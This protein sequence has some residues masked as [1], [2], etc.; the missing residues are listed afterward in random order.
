[1]VIEEQFTS[2]E[3]LLSDSDLPLL[4]MFY[5]PWCGPSH[6]M[7]TVLEQVESR[8]SQ[9][10]RIAKINSEAHPDL[11][12]RYHVHALPSFVLFKQKQPIGQIEVEQ[13][14]HLLSVERFIPRLQGL[15]SSAS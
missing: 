13:T 2:L 8:M 6:L 14:E 9:E 10:L 15:L 12:T 1:M 4:V 11:A 7:D 5:A 3:T